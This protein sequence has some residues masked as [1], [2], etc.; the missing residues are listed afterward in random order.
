VGNTAELL[1][2]SS[3][4]RSTASNQAESII[5]DVTELSSITHKSRV[6]EFYKLVDVG[7]WDGIILAA[8][9][10]EGA[11]DSDSLTANDFSP[12][13][14]QDKAKLQAQVVDL[15]RAICPDEIGQQVIHLICLVRCLMS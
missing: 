11:S 13:D 7:D 3:S 2:S 5:S 15:V 12:L 6:L 4:Q 8:S 1:A 10:L 9:M 14:L